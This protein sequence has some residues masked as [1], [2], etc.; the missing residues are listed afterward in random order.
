MKTPL[1]TREN[2]V[3]SEQVDRAWELD[4]EIRSR[5]KELSVLK[6]QL[7]DL[8]QKYRKDQNDIFL[9]GHQHRAKV[10]F[11]YDTI[12]M[13]NGTSFT[14]A[15]RVRSM[16][17]PDI[18]KTEDRVRLRSNVTLKT[19]KEVLGARYD[20]L[21]EDDVNVVFDTTAF[22]QWCELRRSSKTAHDDEV[23]KFIEDHVE[24][25]KNTPRVNFPH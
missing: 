11:C 16:T 6:Q 7:R 20:E 1:T 9:V 10:S 12:S 25:K 13:K 21:L 17:G 8:A 2:E 5:E 15:L 24:R 4:D 3:S 18:V 19:L 23:M 14:D 22:G